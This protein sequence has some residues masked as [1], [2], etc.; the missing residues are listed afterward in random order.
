[1]VFPETTHN[2]PKNAQVNSE[3]PEEIL[4]LPIHNLHPWPLLIFTETFGQVFWQFTFCR[5][6]LLQIWSA[7]HLRTETKQ[8]SSWRQPQQSPQKHQ[9]WCQQ[10]F[11][12]PRC[13][14]QAFDKD[15]YIWMVEGTSVRHSQL[16]TFKNRMLPNSS[17]FS[18]AGVIQSQQTKVARPIARLVVIYTDS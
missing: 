14:K 18:V 12:H 8:P 6:G 13:L 7:G 2:V 3:R 11:Q 10:G 9:R 15:W 16:S 5:T 1:M 17:F 4:H